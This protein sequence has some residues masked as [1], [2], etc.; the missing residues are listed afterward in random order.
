VTD[1]SSEDLSAIQEFWRFFAPRRTAIAD[2]TRGAAMR[3]RTWAPILARLP[4]DEAAKQDEQSQRL[5][6]RAIMHGEWEPYLASLR[7]QGE[8]YAVAGVS[9]AAWF[10]II[11]AYRDSVSE[12]L[13]AFLR[14]DPQRH[15][16]AVVSVARGMNVLV[17]IAIQQIGEAYL[18]AKQRLVARSEELHRALFEQSPAPMWMYD[19]DTLRIIKVN[20]AA[21]RHYGYSRDQFM[22]LTIADIRP[23]EDLA[24]M[25]ADVAGADGPGAVRTW[26]HRKKD[27]S[28]ITVEVHAN[29][30]IVDDKPVRLVLV[31]DVTER[32][33]T[34]Q[35]LRKTEDQLRH[36]QKME[37][38]GRLAGGVAHDF[39]NVLT[40]V[41]SYACFL[42]ESIEESDRRREDA[43][44]IRRAAERATGIT[45]QLLTLSRQ[46]I[47]R[48]RPVDLDALVAGFLPMLRRFVGETVTLAT[49]YG[50]VPAVIG[51]PGQMEQV[52]MN[53][54]VNAHDA[55]PG[56]GRLTIESRLVEL[57]A[58]T[59]RPLDLQPGRYVELAVTD[60]GTGMDAATQRQIFEPFF[61]TKAAGKGTGLGLSIVHGIVTQAGGRISVYSEPGHGTTFR[62]RL[63][64]ASG[65]VTATDSERVDAPRTL[66]SLRVLVIDDQP[67]VRAVAVRVLQDAG[68]K[69]IEA[70]TAVEARR[71]CVSHDDPIDL[72][73]VDVVLSDGRGD[74]LIHELQQIRPTLAFVLMSGYP[75]G[76]LAPAGAAPDNLI[77]K[78]FGP[79]ELRTAVARACGASTGAPAPA[80]PAAASLRQR[81]LVV[82]DDDAI[83]RTVMRM[84]QKADF[85]VV[86]VDSGYKAITVLESQPVD[87]VV[88][89]VQMPDGGGLDLLRAVR[90]VDLDVPVILMTGAPSVEAA[91]E[92]VEYGAFRYLTKPL[93]PAAFVGTVKHAARAH[94]LARLRRDAYTVTGAHAG[95]TDRAGLEVRF[96]QAVEA[97]WMAY[98]PIVH[99][100]SGALFGI[101]ALMRTTE[102]SL[103]NPGALLDAATQ[104]GRLPVIGRKV[105][106][107]SG[108]AIAT[109]PDQVA[110]F[111]NLHPEDL[112]DADLVDESSPLAK[113]ASK[114]ILEVTER[115]S[116][117]A[118]PLLRERIARIR[119]LGFRIAVD[120]IGAG[121]SGLTSFTELTPEV[122]KID[123]SLVRDVHQSALK[124]RTIGALC[125]LCHEVGT[126]VVGE[127]VET[128]EERDTLVGLGC[129]L[130]QGYLI[131]RPKRE[132]P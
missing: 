12:E 60:T 77:A 124:Q 53:L 33:K 69:V 94:A 83:R 51:D 96:E 40:V 71:I 35:A 46:G 32:V 42:E 131:A 82:D 47:T 56:G 120:D 50:R 81:A 27:G 70:A 1:F 58:D 30:F 87:V 11:R 23:P 128:F 95:V 57:D 89:D 75:A 100:S 19:R 105:R 28:I 129:D 48:P 73:L 110:L 39:N 108:A 66:P 18:D 55:M 130:L 88:S 8:R 10:E 123:M 9:Y 79:S 106:A 59:A 37:A 92:A 114:V 2:R 41:Q 36:A 113:I 45:R 112:F 78:P 68:C 97:M 74:V 116:L 107:L 49:R 93:D 76:A 3:S 16:A 43:V 25:R 103:P 29:D 125:R 17:H 121:Y 52:L 20:D 31:H 118:S 117:E 98:Q 14:D 62:V 6:A 101:E 63:P 109:R 4:A 38:I 115:A 80:T 126:L 104:L 61:T 90:R 64:I 127:G 85:E 86:D 15:T 24:E 84:L 119:Q 44:E 65:D 122:V 111:V 91:A 54:A 132:L 5:Q 99:A 26:R 34:E 13:T 67:D 21:V 72:A 102:P 7:E 22:S